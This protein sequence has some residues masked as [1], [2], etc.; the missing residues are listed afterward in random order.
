M[1]FTNHVATIAILS[2]N[3]IAASSAFAAGEEAT[4][5]A[6]IHELE[7]TVLELKALLEQQACA[8][9]PTC[10][11][12][13]QA[14]NVEDAVLHPQPH[15]STYEK[16][17]ISVG[18]FAKLDAIVSD[19]SKAPIRGIGEDF[20]IPASIN[21]S[22]VPSDPNLNL[23]AKETRFWLKSN[24][25][26]ERGDI[27]TYFEIDFMASEQGNERTVNAYSP[28]LRHAYISTNRWTVG[29]TWSTF[30]DT[31]SVPDYLD[32]LGP[33]G[34]ANA[35][36]AQI[37]YTLP[38][39]KGS[40]V[41]ALENPVTTLTP[42]GGGSRIVAEDSAIPDVIVRRNW[43]GNW[44]TLSVAGLL[45]EL[46]ID[47]AGFDDSEFGSAIALSGRFKIGDQDD[48]RWQINYGDAMGR[49]M[50]MNSYNVGALDANGKINLTTQYGAL[51]AYRHVWNDNMHSTLG[52]SF[53]DADNDTAL[54]GFDVPESIESVH[55]N[56]IWSPI[57]RMSLGA[58]YIWG[59][60]TDENGNDGKLSRIQLSAIYRY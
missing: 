40:W 50:G 46:R 10:S 32:D 15:L 54:S 17:T 55:A 16:T 13:E 21:T 38:V 56:L 19:Y 35:R 42:F 7:Q 26:T 43:A 4:H 25:P 23:H 22:G 51:A 48:F 45:R 52:V 6:R 1:K 9:D 11:R 59:R 27:S 39:E 57:Q 29:Q 49:Y 33:V 44:G 36:Q 20:F 18:G 8:S 3:L 37:R 58:E 34:V 2:A 30:G 24:T 53:S 5:E 12:V 41:F 60:R 14:K 31:A 28:R 47:T